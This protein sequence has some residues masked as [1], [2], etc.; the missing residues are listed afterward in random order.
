M[1][2]GV[3]I[4]FLFFK[5]YSRLAYRKW[6]LAEERKL[7]KL[8]WDG[9]FLHSSAIILFAF[10]SPLI[11]C[12]IENTLRAQQPQMTRRQSPNPNQLLI[13]LEVLG[14]ARKVGTLAEMRKN[15]SAILRISASIPA[16]SGSSDAHA[17]MHLW[18]CPLLVRNF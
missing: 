17:L 10:F 15:M 12:F 3:E 8:G 2:I 16:T 1:A 5:Q 11:P 6:S 9:Y 14:K 7:K 18:N 4:A 13:L